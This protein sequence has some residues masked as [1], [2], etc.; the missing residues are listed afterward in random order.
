[1]SMT[2]IGVLLLVACAGL[3]L[4]TA[5]GAGLLLVLVKAGV[6]GQYWLKGE[7]PVQEGGDYQLEQSHDVS[8][9]NMP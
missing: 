2:S 8:K 6:I 7:A 4:I 3:T 5:L 9:S 1:M